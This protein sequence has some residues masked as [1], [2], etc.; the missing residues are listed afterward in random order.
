MEEIDQFRDA[1][2]GPAENIQQVQG[3]NGVE[4]REYGVHPNDPENAGTQDDDHRGGQAAAQT[5]GSGDGAVHQRGE[6]VG[7][8]HDLQARQARFHHLRLFGKQPQEFSAE[9]DQKG[10]HHRGDAEGQPQAQHVALFHSLAVPGAVILAHKAGTGQVDRRHHVVNQ[11]VGVGRRCVA[12]HHHGI[13]GVDARLN[14]QVCDGEDGVLKP[15]G[16]GN[17]QHLTAF[18]RIQ[19]QL[20][21]VQANGFRPTGQRQHD[22]PRGNVLGEG[23]GQGH[24]RL[25]HVKDDDE[26]QVQDHVQHA[27]NGEK[28]QRMPGVAGGRQHPVAKV[29]HRQ[30]RH[31]QQINAQIPNSAG[32]QFLFGAQQL[33]QG[34][35][36]QKAERQQQSAGDQQQNG[37]GVHRAGY[38]LVPPCA[39]VSRRDHVDA[40]AHADEEPR[41][42]GHQD[43]GGAHR[44][45]GPGPGKPPHHGD[46]GHVEQNLQHI[47]QHQGNAESDNG[48]QHR[49]LGQRKR[50]GCAHRKLLN[51]SNNKQKKHPKPFGFGR[52]VHHQG[53]EPGTP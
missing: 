6:G 11:G 31:A 9:D 26:K 5:A 42:Q 35:G 37:R 7:A 18:E 50:M 47:G 49:P 29:E 2:D 48:R 39:Q 13:E 45:Q 24:A 28:Q 22:E 43:R 17:G 10:A 20:G 16:N 44:P 1:G 51:I 52:L 12:L 21:A 4:V 15:G 3:K 40:A 53:L 41:E 30:R 38:V 25:R 34:R 23:R 46:I 36:E 32:Q 14:K 8:A 19:P 27:R 33:Q